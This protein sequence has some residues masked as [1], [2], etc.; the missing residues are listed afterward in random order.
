M[1]QYRFLFN[2]IRLG[3]V[4]VRNRVVFSAHLTN[5]AENNRP[6]AKLTDYYRE[7]ARGGAGL[8]IT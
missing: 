2:P 6:S 8:I 4:R 3:P 7:R 5:F 1:S